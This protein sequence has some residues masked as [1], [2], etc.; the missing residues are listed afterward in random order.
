MAEIKG[1]LCPHCGT[2]NNF[3]ADQAMA[4]P[5]GRC[6][7]K[8]FEGRALAVLPNDIARHAPLGA[9]PP[10][11]IP[12]LLICFGR[13]PGQ[14]VWVDC[15]RYAERYE[16]NL[17]VLTINPLEHDEIMTR[18]AI[19]GVPTAILLRDGR[20]ADRTM[21]APSDRRD[22]IASM[23]QRQGLTPTRLFGDAPAAET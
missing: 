7:R 1:A 22:P 8:L 6:E 13:I 18:Y 10:G 17:R 20:E 11:K 12:V 15:D 9:Q 5:C 16:P 19:R 4:A 3:Y 14:S 23:L 21:G 2:H